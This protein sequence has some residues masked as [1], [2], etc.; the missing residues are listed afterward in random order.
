MIGIIVKPVQVYGYSQGQNMG[1]RWFLA[2]EEYDFS[3]PH[4]GYFNYP[5]TLWDTIIQGVTYSIPQEFFTSEITSR[6]VQ[7][8]QAY[9]SMGY[10]IYGIETGKRWFLRSQQYTASNQHW[11]DWTRGVSVYDIVI[12]EK[13]Y[14]IPEEVIAFIDTEHPSPDMRGEEQRRAEKE[15]TDIAAFGKPTN[16]VEQAKNYMGIDIRE[17]GMPQVDMRKVRE[18]EAFKDGME[19]S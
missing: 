18:L 9:E 17:D 12:E 16:V 15:T 6:T 10:D 11:V 19:K 14:S 4:H 1:Q 3:N 7:F 5:T 2:R 8:I 13:T